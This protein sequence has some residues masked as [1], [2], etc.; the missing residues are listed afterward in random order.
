MTKAELQK[1]IAR[2]ESLNDFI[3]TELCQ[4]DEMMRKIGFSNGLQTV[5]STANEIISK[6]IK[7]I[8][9]L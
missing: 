6:N 7:D 3:G 1:K 5:K 2:I 4:I 8:D 9:S